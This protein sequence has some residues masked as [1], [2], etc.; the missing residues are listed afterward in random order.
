MSLRPWSFTA[1]IVPIALT[2][3]VLR[4]E[5]EEGA[6]NLFSSNYVLCFA[7]T[8]CLHASANLFNTYYD[9]KSGSDTKKR[10]DDR[11]ILDGHVSPASVHRS[12]VLL[13]AAGAASA[14]ALGA[15][16]DGSAARQVAEIV[17][18]AILLSFFYTADPLSLKRYALGDVTVFLMFGP[19]LMS[20]VQVAVTG[21]LPLAPGDNGAVLAY[22]IPVGL[23][24]TAILHANN[25]RDIQDD[26]KAGIV[27]VAMKL[28][29]R[30]SYYM[31]CCLMLS[32]YAF[33]A[34]R[35]A[36][37]G[38]SPRQLIVALSAPWAL[39]VTRLFASGGKHMKTLP[40]RIAQHNLLFGTLLTMGL[41]DRMFLARVL[42]TCLYYLG[43]V[44]NIL[45]WSYNI[46]LVHMKLSNVFGVWWPMLLS[47]A[48]FGG[49]CLYQLICSV[50]F[51]LGFHELLM[52]KMLLVW[53]VP[54]TV[55][56][57]DMWTIEHE[58]PAHKSPRS[59]F[60]SFA[61]RDVAVFPTEFDNEF[62]HFFKNVGMIGGLLVYIETASSAA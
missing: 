35:V 34:T 58:H 31:H 11:G 26:K 49:A 18:V 53:I 2:G 32:S 17:A 7:L 59:S 46:H 42:L 1:S 51:M 5:S 20:G 28:G 50:L 8:L 60:P 22:S 15:L 55:T 9:F 21:T 33:V 36:L 56:V 37:C 24:T 44:N 52:A 25:A 12:A 3:A 10:A 13:A 16:L 40:Q 19:L 27:T 45:M 47:R 43:G 57:H 41:C 29:V 30:G 54:I 23:L 39:Y 38:S 62:V 14:A 61:R 4:Y 6:I 48:A